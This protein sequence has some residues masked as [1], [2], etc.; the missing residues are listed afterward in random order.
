MEIRAENR[1][2]STTRIWLTLVRSRLLVGTYD[3]EEKF[4]L[5]T[6]K[7]LLK[8]QPLMYSYNE[9]KYLIK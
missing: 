2:T 8:R 1:T 4:I 6:Y 5:P 7:V 3:E 9:E